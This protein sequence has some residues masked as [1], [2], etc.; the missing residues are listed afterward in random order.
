MKTETFDVI[1]E[2]IKVIGA[3]VF[4]AVVICGFYSILNI[5]EQN[6]D[7]DNIKFGGV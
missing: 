4:I 1:I 6:D 2:S 7:E 5:D 3:I